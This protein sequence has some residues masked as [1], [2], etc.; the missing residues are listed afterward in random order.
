MKCW[1]D[2]KVGDYETAY[3]WALETQK[4]AQNFFAIENNDLMAWVELT[5]GL[6]EERKGNYK[7][8]EVALK[9]SI[10]KLDKGF[11]G[12]MKHNDQAFAHML[13]GNIY[14][15]KGQL[16]KAKD[17]YQFAEKVYDLLL[18]KKEGAGLSELYT[19]YAI[20]GAILKDDLLAKH[21]LDL[22]TKHFK[23]NQDERKKILKALK[24][25]NLTIMPLPSYD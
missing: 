11:G 15:A 9:S 18:A 14:V 4:E 7:K 13:L 17:E 10:K 19:K 16:V 25:N 21:Y 6:C 3:K 12:A 5:I 8:A 20:L 24:E 2:F 22:H 23:E 1:V